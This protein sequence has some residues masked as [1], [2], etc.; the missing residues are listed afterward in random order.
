VVLAAITVSAV[1]GLAVAL[2][3]LA[4]V[5]QVAKAGLM[6]W[7]GEYQRSQRAGEMLSTVEQNINREL[8]RN[9]STG[10]AMS[11]EQGV[12]K[13]GVRH[14]YPHLAT[15]LLLTGASVVSAIYG[16]YLLAA[17]AQ[18][19]AAALPPTLIVVF[20]TTVVIVE[21]VFVWLVRQRWCAIKA[22]YEAGVPPP[23]DS[24]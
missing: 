20:T 22:W 4:A 23:R 21:S 12:T 24:I 10:L 19:Q 17:W 14:G 15:I 9:R 18:A 11:W 2:L 6:I 1:Q 13:T 7:F 5:P 3:V 8:G 16:F